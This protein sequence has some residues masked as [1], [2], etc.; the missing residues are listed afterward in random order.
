MQERL[1]V[2]GKLSS[3]AESETCL[4]RTRPCEMTV[5]LSQAEPGRHVITVAVLGRTEALESLGVRAVLIDC[6]Q[7]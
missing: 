3:V 2:G 6:F 5:E 4:A 7:S 1:W